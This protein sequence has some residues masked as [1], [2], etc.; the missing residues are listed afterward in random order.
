MDAPELD[1]WRVRAEFVDGLG[2]AFGVQPGGFAVGAGF[3]D[4]LAEVGD[5]QRD[6]RTG[7]GDHAEGELH[8]VE[9]RLR[10]ELRGAVELLEA[11]QERQPVKDAA[12]H[13][14]RGAEGEG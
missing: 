7:P 4:A 6:E 1:S 8:Q 12:R 5:D 13:K 14:D 9:E 3:V 11:E 2:E 10:V